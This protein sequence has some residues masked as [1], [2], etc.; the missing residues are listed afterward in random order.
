MSE[1]KNYHFRDVPKKI[2]CPSEEE[3]Q[4][5]LFNWARMQEHKHPELKW[6]HAI[7]NGGQRSKPEAARM[8][9]G[10]VKPGVSDIFLPAARGKYHGLYIELKKL[11]GGRARDE[12]IDFIADMLKEGYYAAVKRGWQ[13]ASK[14]I[15]DYLEGRLP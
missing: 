5:T 12:Q 1:K 2:P 15:L 6:M 9:A 7:P 8:K 10:G 11:R 3:E 13:E 14:L 4:I